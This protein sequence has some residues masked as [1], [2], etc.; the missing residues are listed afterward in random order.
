V[1]DTHGR[2]LENARNTKRANVNT[3]MKRQTEE[4]LTVQEK[5]VD[6]EALA[7]KARDEGDLLL[8]LVIRRKF[9]ATS[10]CGCVVLKAKIA[11]SSMIPQNLKS[12]SRKAVKSRRIFVRAG[13]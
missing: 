13:P 5:E 7:R 1:F 3:V 8:L 2:T 4:D 6:K 12:V 11:I 9:I 10:T